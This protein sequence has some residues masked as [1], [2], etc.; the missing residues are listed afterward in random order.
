MFFEN[1]DTT[2][3]NERNV[4]GRRLRALHPGTKMNAMRKTAEIVRVLAA[5]CVTTAC[6]SATGCSSSSSAGA[7]PDAGPSLCASD[8][9]AQTYTAGMEQKGASGALT[10]KLDSI[11]PNP[12]VK[13]NNEWKV[14]VVDA[15]G[16]P[17]SGATI[18]VKPYMPD[19]GHGSS[20]IP[21]VA[22]GADPGSYD[23]TLLNLFMPGIWQVTFTVTTSANVTDSAMFTFC[24]ND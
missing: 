16:A 3:V 23:V 9:R 22:A 12:V 1:V 6:V 2:K 13:G 19:H 17:V 24:V 11:N 15:G 10:V 18:T 8:S 7:T 14:T 21:Q 4:Q 5:L 20:I